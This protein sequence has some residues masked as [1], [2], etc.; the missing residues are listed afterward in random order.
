VPGT[1]GRTALR[2][3]R[4]RRRLLRALPPSPARTRLLK[5]LVR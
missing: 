4:E 1:I 2:L 5:G 3:G